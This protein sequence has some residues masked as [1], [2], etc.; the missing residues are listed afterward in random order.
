MKILQLNLNHC[1]TA[2]NLLSQ[3]I[4]E[5]NI[6][7]A[8]LCER[9]KNVYDATWQNDNTSRTSIWSCGKYAF[10]DLLEDPKDGFIRGKIQGIY[11]Y[12]CYVSPNVT[13]SE[14]E[15]YIDK[16]VADASGHNPK[17]ICGDFNAWATNWGCRSTNAR[18]RVLLEA[19][20]QLDLVLGNTGNSQTFRRGA[21]GSVVDLTFL[22]PVLSK[23]LEW[24]VSENYTHSDHQAIVFTLGGRAN[25]VKT[26]DS[27]Y[28]GWAQNKFD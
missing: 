10:Q 2:Q 1:A 17:V 15:F 23:E 16:L 11:F 8:I 28:N 22:S 13:Q 21:T 19:F 18:G 3:A 9:Y 14:Y 6:D 5:M 12:S 4:T 20:T 26:P 25:L 27:F 24:S 7:I